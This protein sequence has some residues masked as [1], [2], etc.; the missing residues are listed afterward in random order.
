MIL[1]TQLPVRF[2]LV[3]LSDA[4]VSLGASSSLHVVLR[5]QP[6]IRLRRLFSFGIPFC[7][8]FSRLFLPHRHFDDRPVGMIQNTNL[9]QTV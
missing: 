4:S 6:G 2:R 8:S 5:A 7:P 3:W 9:M 1:L